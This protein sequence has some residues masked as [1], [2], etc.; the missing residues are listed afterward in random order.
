MK[1]THVY[2]ALA[3]AGTALPYWQLITWL[4]ENGIDIPEFFSQLTTNRVSGFAWLDV[5]ISGVVVV[6]LVVS[7]RER[8]G[9]WWWFPLAGLGVG[10]SLSLPLFLYMR[11][12]NKQVIV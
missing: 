9:R 11:E 8:L 10:V 1:L 3:I 5:V 2:L 12:R 7:Q 4:T 6:V